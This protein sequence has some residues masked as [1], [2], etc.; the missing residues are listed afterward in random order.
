[1]VVMSDPWD[2][3]KHAVEWLQKSQGQPT[4]FWMYPKPACNLSSLSSTKIYHTILV[5]AIPRQ[6]DPSGRYFGG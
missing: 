2:F 5:G 3:L 4:T 1:M 6:G